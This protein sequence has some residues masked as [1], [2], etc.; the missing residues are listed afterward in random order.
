MEQFS[1]QS[2]IDLMEIYI[3]TLAEEYEHQA[4]QP[5][6]PQKGFTQVPQDKPLALVSYGW[7]EVLYDLKK[8]S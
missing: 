3:T 7:L 1:S 2:V 8:N 4:G 5:Y 6:D